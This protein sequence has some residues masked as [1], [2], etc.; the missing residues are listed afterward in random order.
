MISGLIFFICKVRRPAGPFPRVTFSCSSVV[1][2]SVCLVHFLEC[3][4]LLYCFINE[5]FMFFF[6]N[7]IFMLFLYV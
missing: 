2:S 5:I 4:S 6:L 1:R 7:E 3:K